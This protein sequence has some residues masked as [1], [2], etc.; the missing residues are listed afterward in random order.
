MSKPMVFTMG[1]F[2]SPTIGHAKLV[3]KVISHAKE[4]GGEARIYPSRSEGNSSNPIPIKH[5]VKHLKDL[6]PGANIVDSPDMISPHHVMR[7]L[8]DDGHR[9]VTMVVGQDRVDEFK[10]HIGKYVKK[11]TEPGYDP[12]KHY[13]LDHFNVV[14][15]GDRD[16]KASGV[17]GASGTKMRQFAKDGDFH[18]FAQNTPTK[19]VHLA[20]R[21]FN[22]VKNNLKEDTILEELDHENFGPMLDTFVSFASDKLGLKSLPK[23]HLKKQDSQDSSQPSFGGYH[24]GEKH[25][26]VVT[27]NRH[28]MDVYRTVAHELVHHKQNEEGRLNDPSDGETGSNIENEANSEAGKILRWYAKSNPNTF[29]LSQIVESFIAEGIHDPGIFKAVFLAGGPGSGK[30]FILKKTLDGHGLREINSDVAL[31]F[32]MKKENLSLA[33]PDNERPQRELVRGR[34]KNISKNKQRLSLLGRQGLIINGTADDPAKIARIKR[35]LEEMGYHTMMVFVDTSD[36]VSKQR[37]LERGKLGGRTVPEDIR[38]QK[39]QL[40]QVNKESLRALFGDK[41]FVELDNNSDLRLVSP[42][43]AKDINQEYL[44]IF[45]R[46]SQFTNEIPNSSAAVDWMNSQFKTQNITKHVPLKKVVSTNPTTKYRIAAR[47]LKLQEQTMDKKKAPSFAEAQIAA[48]QAGSLSF[49]HGGKKHSTKQVGEWPN[50]WIQKMEQNR[51]KNPLT[52]TAMP[53]IKPEKPPKPGTPQANPVGSVTKDK[54][55]TPINHVIHAHKNK[56]DRAFQAFA[57]EHGAGD[58]GTKKLR[59]TYEKDTPGEKKKIKEDG[60]TGTGPEFDLL[61][62]P[63]GIIPSMY[64]QYL[65]EDASI[66]KWALKETTLDKF[67]KKYGDDAVKKLLEAA[68]KLSNY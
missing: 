29:G 7:K 47:K 65:P 22:S 46:I 50:V 48:R 45:K 63:G 30:D 55:G 13:D 28:P 20:K 49:D 24:P 34:A 1:R 3:D 2:Q 18:S 38:S 56:V 6:F 62:A 54:L 8:A 58:W 36:E 10:Q 67:V 19:N 51:S 52:P 60:S 64:E 5:K 27:K 68:N 66:R 57:E 32:L 53:K 61:K 42:E 31:E 44:K 15:A 39:W 59:D 33:M 26:T 21:I 4:I 9:H 40:T 17:T 25:I 37:N 43:K 41:N 23:I 12:K 35:E 11:K 16:A 14:S